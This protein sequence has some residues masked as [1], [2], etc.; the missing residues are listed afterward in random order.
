MG[1]V[2]EHPVTIRRVWRSELGRVLFFVVTAILS[3]VASGY[4]PRSVISGRIFSISGTAYSL[5]L[6]LFWLLP[7]TILALTVLRIYNSRYII[8][9][10]GVESREGILSFRQ[11][12]TRFRH[13]DIRSIE[14]DQT[15]LERLLDVGTVEIG[16]AATGDIEVTF[17]G[18]GAP[19]MIQ[20]LLQGIREA[21]LKIDDAS[22][23]EDQ[24][25]SENLVGA[26]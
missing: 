6:P 19:K 13:L 21:R 8:D 22:D 12:I 7:A 5:H 23:R 9:E 2:L 25:Q 26:I 10:D 3:T 1:T 16:T 24:I 20:Q 18:I 14:V 11:S 17:D 4:L 15:L